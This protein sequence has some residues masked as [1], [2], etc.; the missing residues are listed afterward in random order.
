MKIDYSITF[1]NISIL[2]SIK[3]L[4]YEIC[5]KLLVQCMKVPY[6]QLTI[7]LLWT[8]SELLKLPAA[9]RSIKLK[10]CIDKLLLYTFCDHMYLVLM[11]FAENPD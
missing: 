5:R 8:C 1:R 7:T 6:H 11:R 10:L 2:S 9:V 4:D 3:Y